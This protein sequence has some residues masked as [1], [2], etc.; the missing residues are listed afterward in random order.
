[1]ATDRYGLV[2]STRSVAARDAFVQGCDRALTMHHLMVLDPALPGTLSHAEADALRGFAE[3]EKAASTRRAY[4]A[5]FSAFEAWC[6]A[7][8]LC[9]LPASPRAAHHASK[10]EKSAR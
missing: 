4:R 8:G 6:T 9:S 2:L 10:A 3:N 1:M 7:R 5:D